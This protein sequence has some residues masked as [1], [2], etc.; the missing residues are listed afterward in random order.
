[1]LS[2]VIF[3]PVTFLLGACGVGGLLLA[4]LYPRITAGAALDRR[5]EVMAAAGTVATLRGGA[6]DDSR[7]KRALEVTLREAEEKLKSKADKRFKPSLV[8]RMRQGNIRWSKK[9]YYLICV[10][11]GI[12]A[13][14]LFLS[15]AGLGMLP[16]VGFGVAAGLLVPPWYVNFTRTRR[17]E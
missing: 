10:G 9:T 7:R 1:M 8:L 4:G 14:L 5:L 3:L 15:V 16:A 11:T 17:D 12:V 2:S 13:F 6:T